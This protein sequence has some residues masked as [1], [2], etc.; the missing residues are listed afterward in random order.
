MMKAFAPYFFDVINHQDN[1]KEICKVLFFQISTKRSIII[2]ILFSRL[3]F[4]SFLE[5]YTFSE[6]TSALLDHHTGATLQL[7]PTLVM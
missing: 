5:M 4:A 7:M 2:I 6:V 1:A 3:I